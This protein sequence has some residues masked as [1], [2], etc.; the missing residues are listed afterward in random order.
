MEKYYVFC[1]ESGTPSKKDNINHFIYACILIKESDLVKARNVRAHISKNFLQGNIIKA[2]NKAI[3]GNF[4]KRIQILNYLCDN[5]NFK[6]HS[7]IIDK[8]ALAG[9]GL[10]IKQVFIKFFQKLLLN[11]LSGKVASFQV[12][13]DS[14]GDDNFQLDLKHYLLKSIPRF[15]ANL[16]N[17]DNSYHLKSDEEEELIQFADLI[18]NSM[19]QI[20]SG[21]KKNINWKQL[22][23]ILEPKLLKPIVFPYNS[24][25]NQDEDEENFTVSNNIYSSVLDTIERFKENNRDKVKNTIVNH[26]VYISRIFP[27]KL[28]ETYELRE[29]IKRVISQEVSLE[30]IRLLIRDLRYQGVLIISKSGKSGYKIAVNEEDI[31]SY[32][33]H[34]LSY[35]IPMLEKANIADEALQISLDRNNYNKINKFLKALKEPDIN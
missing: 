16:F 18:A 7:L 10:D 15:Q 25:L 21:S 19:L 35:I 1:D 20:Y 33:N 31:S 28:I 27:S 13:M 9:R 6:I 11:D 24:V 29:E 30:K 2:G 8:E 5:L 12:F 23:E 17:Q 4:K 26:L 14:T 22:Y 32:F 34:Y 3:R